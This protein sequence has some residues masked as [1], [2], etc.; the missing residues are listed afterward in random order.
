MT[1]INVPRYGK[2]LSKLLGMRDRNPSNHVATEVFPTL[3]LGVERPE[4]DFI[5]GVKRGYG[6]SNV[7]PV[8]GQYGASR[9]ASQN[10]RALIVV[11]S[12]RVS[13]PT[14]TN[15]SFQLGLTGGTYL[16][17]LDIARVGDGRDELYNAAGTAQTA[18][19]VSS[20]TSATSNIP[21]V[22][23]VKEIDALADTPV[24][25]ISA[26][27]IIWSDTGWNTGVTVELR[28]QQQRL[29]VNWEWTE[30]SVDPAEL[31]KG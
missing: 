11:T 1:E 6:H 12:C 17:S 10:A 16:A 24:E 20:G 21:A 30:R 15:L 18:A 27:I 28:D 9:I 14:S 29:K 2:I 23:L 3:C 22:R 4:W 25:M 13:C 19:V 26:P 5:G 7:A 31:V 8:A